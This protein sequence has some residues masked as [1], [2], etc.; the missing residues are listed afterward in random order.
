MA[1]SPI[2]ATF[3]LLPPPDQRARSFVTSSIVNLAVFG[4]AIYISSTARQVVEQHYE[5]TELIMPVLPP[6]AKIPK[7]PPTPPRVKVQPPRV[8]PPR[9]QPLREEPRP[10]QMEA[11]LDTP[12]MPH[13]KPQIKLALQPRPA[14]AAAMPAQTHLI[15]PSVAPVHLGQIFGVTPNPN[16][17]RP[18]TIAAIG[19]PYGGQ[20]GPAVAPHGVVKSTGMGG[21]TRFGNGG[22]GVGNGGGTVA[23]AGLPGMTPVSSTPTYTPTAV[24]STSVEIVSKPPVRYTSEARQSRVEGDVVLSV[25]FLASGQVVV[26]GVLHGLGHGLDEEAVREA[27]Q[28]QFRPATSNGKPVDL[29]TRIIITFQLA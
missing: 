1:P 7:P 24:R 19:N 17:V 14:L 20:R 22:S 26:H 21:S 18:A 6:A 8:Q 11:K 10:V 27:R 2:P 29:T 13:V 25:T 4:I 28:I 12:P 16:S 5:R 9:V 15:H 23:S 3:G